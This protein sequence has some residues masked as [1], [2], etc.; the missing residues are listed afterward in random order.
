MAAIPFRT[1]DFILPDGRQAY[2]V[3][4]SEEIDKIRERLAGDE[5]FEVFVY[6]SPEYRDA[7]RSSQEHF[8]QGLK[9]FRIR[10][11]DAYDEFDALR[12]RLDA[13]KSEMA[14]VSY[15]T[16]PLDANFSKYGYSAYLRTYNAG[17]ILEQSGNERRDW[18]LDRWTGKVRQLYEKPIIRQYIHNGFLWRASETTQ[19]EP[20]ELFF[21]LLFAGT[22]SING[23]HAADDPT[24]KEL[25][26]FSITFILGWKIW[27]ELNMIIDWIQADDILQRFH[28][29]HAECIR[30]YVSDFD[31]IDTPQRL[32]TIWIAIFLELTGLVFLVLF[33]RLSSNSSTKFAQLLYQSFEFYPAFNIEHKVERTNC[34]VTLVFG[35]SVVAIIYQNT[36]SAF[37]GLNAFFG[38]A[39]LGLTQAFML[40][41]MYFEVDGA[42]LH[43]HAFRRHALSSLVWQ[44]IH[45]PFI[46][47]FLLAATALSKLV[48][49]TD[50]QHANILDLTRTYQVKSDVEIL[51]G[52]RWFYCVGLGISLFSMGIISICHIHKE[53]KG[54]KNQRIRIPKSF[55]ML[56]RLAI[57]IILFCLPLANNLNSL[58]LITT[59]TGLVAW[60]LVLELWVMSIPGQGLF[61]S[62]KQPT[63]TAAVTAT[64]LELD[65]TGEQKPLADLEGGS[66]KGEG[67]LNRDI[68]VGDRVVEADGGDGG[69]HGN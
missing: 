46:M 19:V 57:C 65:I 30:G 47:G 69:D 16:A 39:A 23:D 4:S 2:T 11:R 42:D 55:R 17:K 18:Y 56:N 54:K 61:G 21:D 5:P 48:L 25:L 7:L 67:G 53:P 12:S 10:H 14:K 37:F 68:V 6:G 50:C 35:Y 38:K 60:V 58:L 31:H 26:P 45:L 43:K 9:D 22:L 3:S 64:D 52:L 27:S 1:S 63:C 59:T 20:F 49:A 51:P 33:I 15:R 44:T 29:K 62:S 28:D 32:A 34:F 40:N 36:A 24:G 41:W 13:I 66:K 8:E